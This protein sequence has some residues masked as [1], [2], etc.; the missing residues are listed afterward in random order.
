MDTDI[1]LVR[2]FNSSN[3]NDVTGVVTCA[4][5]EATAGTSTVC[6]LSSSI[7]IV[8]EFSD[9]NDL[10]LVRLRLWWRIANSGS[11]FLLTFW[12]GFEN[13]RVNSRPS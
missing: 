4:F 3:Q 11:I 10:W 7:G 9:D 13:T 12:F 6:P 5:N 1:G 8:A 2:Q